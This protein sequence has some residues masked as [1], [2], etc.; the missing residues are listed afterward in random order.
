GKMGLNLG[1]NLIDH[2][3]E[4]V[5]FDLNSNAVEEIKSYG[6]KGTS[7]LKELVQSLE[8]PRVLWIMVPHTVVDSVLHD[9][10]PLLDKGDIVIEAG[11]SHYK[12]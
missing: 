9:V 10:T 12:E 4:V 1:Q 8:T 5:G 6:A 11:N 7:D 3:H 2:G